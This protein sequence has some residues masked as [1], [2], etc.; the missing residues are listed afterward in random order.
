MA[1][2]HDL[3]CRFHLAPPPSTTILPLRERK[4]R[5]R[6]HR[7]YHQGLRPTL[8]PRLPFSLSLHLCF[9]ERKK[10]PSFLLVLCSTVER[11]RMLLLPCLLPISPSTQEHRGGGG[12]GGGPQPAFIITSY[13]FVVRSSMD[14]AAFLPSSLSSPPPPSAPRPPSPPPSS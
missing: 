5:Q 9:G 6:R 1:I 10:H 4:R 7:H 8:H 13:A 12:G 3:S 2:H 14:A 11:T